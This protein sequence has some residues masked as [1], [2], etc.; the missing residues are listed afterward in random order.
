MQPTKLAFYHRDW[1]RA[2]TT[3]T[4]DF[5]RQPPFRILLCADLSVFSERLDAR[6]FLDR[7]VG[8]GGLLPHDAVGAS[9]WLSMYL[10]CWHRGS[11]CAARYAGATAKF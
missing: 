3:G 2:Q 9:A 8:R 10:E 5:G 6:Q 4:R 7:A 1:L 11:P